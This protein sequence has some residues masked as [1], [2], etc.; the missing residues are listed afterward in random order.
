MRNS[1]ATVL[2]GVWLVLATACG[3]SND[4]PAGARP[5]AAQLLTPDATGWVDKSRTGTTGIQ[6]RWRGFT[7]S[8][9]LPGLTAGGCHSDVYGE[10]SIVQEPAA[11]RP[12]APT[13]GLGMCAAG[14]I[15]KWIAVVGSRGITP[16]ASSDRAGIVLDLNTPDWAEPRTSKNAP[17]GQPYDAAAHDVAGFSFDIDTEPPPDLKIRV[18]AATVGQEN[19]DAGPEPAFWGG[20]GLGASPVH[21][22]HNEFGWS[23]MG[24]TRLDSS[25]VLSVGFVVSGSEDHAVSYDFCIHHLR[26]LRSTKEAETAGVSGSR[27]G[28]QLLVPDESGWVSR[29]GTGKTEIQGQWFAAADGDTG[30]SCPAAAHTHCSV[31]SEPDPAVGSFPPTRGLGMCTAGVVAKSTGSEGIWGAMI[32]FLLNGTESQV[33]P[34]DA[35]AHGVTGFGFDIDSEPAPGAEIDVQLMTEPTQGQDPFWGGETQAFS[36]VHAGHNEFKWR[37]VGGPWYVAHPPAFDPRKLIQIAFHVSSNSDHDV[38]YRFC[39]GN[40]TALRH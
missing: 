11:D 16:D 33:Y 21:A 39:I 26:A 29:S 40:L 34:Y 32:G 24:P 13:P 3:V 20:L 15:A 1:L 25:G 19:A 38:S 35:E 23:D 36:P 4:S 17:T 8:P 37:D 6:G 30:D 10:C 5:S 18:E 2:A 12:Y 7:G 14:V 9:A 28:D 22:G 27:S 31:Y